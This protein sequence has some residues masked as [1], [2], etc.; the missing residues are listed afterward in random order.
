MTMASGTLDQIKAW[1]TEATQVLEE[2]PVVAI[3]TLNLAV[4]G[5]ATADEVEHA[6][7]Q[8][9]AWQTRRER[10]LS[11]SNTQQ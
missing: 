10:L 11:M 1:V 3:M 5:Q 2:Y 8:L 7:Q 6:H 4:M 9:E